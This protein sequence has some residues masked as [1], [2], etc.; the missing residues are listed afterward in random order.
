MIS[1]CF[2]S[3]VSCLPSWKT[4]DNPDRGKRIEKKRRPCTNQTETKSL[5]VPRGACTFRARGVVFLSGGPLRNSPRGA[6]YI[7]HTN[8]GYRIRSVEVPD[9]FRRGTGYICP[10]HSSRDTMVEQVHRCLG[11][12][13]AI[14]LGVSGR[15]SSATQNYFGG[16]FVGETSLSTHSGREI[17]TRS[18]LE[19]HQKIGG[20]LWLCG[21]GTYANCCARTNTLVCPL[22]K[23]WS[24]VWLCETA[25]VTEGRYNGV[26]CVSQAVRSSRRELAWQAAPP[27][28]Y[29]TRQNVPCARTAHTRAP[30]SE[31]GA[32]KRG[33]EPPPKL[34]N[35]D[36]ERPC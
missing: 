20:N 31:H 18:S 24:F 13:D 30:A 33:Q 23:L 36:G 16:G 3:A 27:Q 5:C 19:L 2:F 4:S 1:P 29:C 11:V 10:T 21:P 26:Y 9:T 32:P 7:P 14:V 8:T 22:N 12:G 15:G 25:I 6:G 35:S 28:Q 17:F 34:P